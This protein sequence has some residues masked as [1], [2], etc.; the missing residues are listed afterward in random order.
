M[1]PGLAG[2]VDAF[3]LYRVTH[4][5]WY[6]APSA[7]NMHGSR[8]SRWHRKHSCDATQAGF[9]SVFNGGCMHEDP[10]HACL[11][12]GSTVGEAAH[13]SAG[14]LYHA[15][16]LLQRIAVTALWVLR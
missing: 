7:N 1:H 14:A 9:L 15:K 16:R 6:T 11:T 5:L 4:H 13:H 10:R 8:G 3:A 2:A 12:A